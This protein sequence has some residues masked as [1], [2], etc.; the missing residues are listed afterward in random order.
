MI[1]VDWSD[2]VHLRIGHVDAAL[3]NAQ[4]QRHA[5]G[6]RLGASYYTTGHRVTMDYTSRIG[7]QVPLSHLQVY[8]LNTDEHERENSFTFFGNKARRYGL[9]RRRTRVWHTSTSPI[10]R[11]YILYVPLNARYIP[12]N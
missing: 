5:W 3:Y 6:Y 8:C 7:G 10:I 9:E 4:F 12:V 1:Q 2:K 11:L